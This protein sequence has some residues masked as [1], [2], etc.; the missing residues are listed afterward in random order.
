MF[1]L[2]DFKLFNKFITPSKP[3][4]ARILCD[5]ITND[6]RQSDN[7]G[8]YRWRYNSDGCL[9]RAF[10][11]NRTGAKVDL[12]NEDG[13][14]PSNAGFSINIIDDKAAATSGSS[15]FSCRIRYGRVLDLPGKTALY[16][17]TFVRHTD[18]KLGYSYVLADLIKTFA[19]ERNFDFVWLN[20][21]ACGGSLPGAK[22]DEELKD[23]Y[24]KAFKSDRFIYEGGPDNKYRI[25]EVD[26]NIPRL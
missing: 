1:K 26:Y 15:V 10:A 20:P 9:D 12:F 22:N 14:Y 3:C 19:E 18:Q 2:S 5:Q 24:T 17:D 8:D 23:F 6:Y 11:L 25:S 7:N 16:I 21:V 13:N 4:P